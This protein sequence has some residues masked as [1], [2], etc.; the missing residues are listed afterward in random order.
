MKKH[1][2]FT[3]MMMVI[4]AAGLQS[5][6]RPAGPAERCA[7][8]ELPLPSNVDSS[9]VVVLRQVNDLHLHM[10]NFP[11]DELDSLRLAR[12][13]ELRQKMAPLAPSYPL[14]ARRLERLFA[15]N[16][17]NQDGKEEEARKILQELIRKFQASPP[18]DNWQAY[19]LAYAHN[20]MGVLYQQI[21][22]IPL[23]VSHHEKSLALNRKFQ[24]WTEAAKDYSNLAE[25]YYY[26]GDTLR[27]NT[28]SDSAYLF[29]SEQARQGF[30]TRGDSIGFA[31][32]YFHIGKIKAQIAYFYGLHGDTARAD[33][34]FAKAAHALQQAVNALEQMEPAGV[35]RA[36]SY[37]ALADIL[38]LRERPELA[39]SALVYLNKCLAVAERL[40]YLPFFKQMI[41]PNL[42]LAYAY[43]GDCERAA[44]FSDSIQA[45]IPAN[46][47]QLLGRPMA[48]GFQAHLD[49]AWSQ[50][51]CYRHNGDLQL[52]QQS[53]ASFEEALQFFEDMQRRF[54]MEQSREAYSGNYFGY[55][56]LAFEAAMEQYRLDKSPE[57]FERLLQLS[58]RGK[59]ITLFQSLGRQRALNE[60]TGEPLALLRRDDE[61]TKAIHAQ[62]GVGG[63]AL[64]A[65][66]R[67]KLAFVDSLKSS[68][69]PAARA[70]YLNRLQNPSVK[71]AQ[72][73]AAFC[74][75]HSALVAYQQAAGKAYALVV[76]ASR[77]TAFE[78]AAGLEFYQMLDRYRK[79]L[80]SEAEY[81]RSSAYPVYQA[82]FQPIHQWLDAEVNQLTIVWDR[83]IQG[84]VFDALLSAPPGQGGFQEWPY[85]NK[86]YAFAYNYSIASVLASRELQA[87][88]T[89]PP[90]LFGGFLNTE[91]SPCSAL[92]LEELRD[93]SL[94][95]FGRYFQ[96]EGRIWE[97]ASSEQFSRLANDYQV[98]LLGMHGC[99]PEG[100]AENVSLFFG[101]QPDG[102]PAWLSAFSVQSLAMRPRLTVLATC[103]NAKGVNQSSE[104]R[105]SV[106][107][108]FLYAGCPAVIA[109][110]EALPEGPLSVIISGF[111]EG[112]AGR[113]QTAARALNQ[114]KRQYL[115]Q[116]NRHPYYWANIILM[117]DPFVSLPKAGSMM[118]NQ[119]N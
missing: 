46:P 67:A 45:M 55:Y 115:E 84:L 62:A 5:G 74:D 43:T 116:Q 83:Q 23:S 69:T 37:N 26:L 98:L 72:V 52:L 78:L 35:E 89:K 11:N 79:G 106:A 66:M 101:R 81:Y 7:I 50:L 60:W 13:L 6:C 56:T 36:F 40:G 112:F 90:Q 9:A 12:L 102:S 24:S 87:V 21:H 8:H 34:A 41:Y 42:A 71:L 107:R 54:S 17:L 49:Q 44:Q 53:I 38:L 113:E 47:E 96:G 103:E 73:R 51:A 109:G 32:N 114:A 105:K 85:L 48:L 61:L 25:A 100:E 75:K 110:N 63:E 92:P 58:D 119:A 108:A 10:E 16:L 1:F 82:I 70:F 28:F 99:K 20:L 88:A 3:S 93:T 33:D 57:H 59:A 39:D 14:F 80:A 2:I 4:L 65:A 91:G 15:F 104:G 118:V 19:E 76:T 18:T 68:R 30:C 31:A 22:D 111:F 29:L 117:G 95:V 86:E 27:A 97:G 77:D 64:E 94:A